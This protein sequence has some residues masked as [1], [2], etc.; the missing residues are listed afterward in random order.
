MFEYFFRYSILF[1]IKCN[2]ELDTYNSKMLMILS[3][4]YHFRNGDNKIELQELIKQHNIW[5]RIGWWQT[6]LL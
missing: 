5:K 6:A 3:L 4:T 1:N 2:A